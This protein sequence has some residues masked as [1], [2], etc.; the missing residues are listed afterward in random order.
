MEKVMIAPDYTPK[1][2]AEFVFGSAD[3]KQTIDAIVTGTIPFPLSGKTGILLFG[4][5]GTGKTELAKLLPKT[6]EKLYSDNDPNVE[7]YQIQKGQ[8][9]AAVITKVERMTQL[10]CI[11]QQYHYVIFD[12][13][14]NLSRDA[15]KSVKSVMNKKNCVF[16]LTTNDITKVENGVM[17]R[18]PPCRV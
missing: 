6:I 17:D 15:M 11:G 13:V 9:G 8:D 4:A 18:C 16:I 10:V 5:N 3:S 1:T 2:L 12:E 7:F 14:D